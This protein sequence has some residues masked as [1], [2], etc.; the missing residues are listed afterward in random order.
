MQSWRAFTELLDPAEMA[1]ADALAIAAG[2]PGIDLM[3]AAG[4]AVAREAVR[5]ALPGSRRTPRI[6]VLC[7]PGNNGG[8][9][10]VAARL[11]AARGFAVELFLFGQAG[12]LKGDARLAADKWTGRVSPLEHF[13]PSQADL[14]VDALFGAGLARDLDGAPRAAVERVNAWRRTGGGKVLAVDVPSG[15]DGRTGKARGVAVEADATVTFFRLKPGH[16]LLPGRRLCGALRLA[17]IG[18]E[19]AVLEALESRTRLNAPGLW[20]SCFPRLAVEGHKYSRGHVLV[21]SGPAGRTGAARLSARGALRVGAGLVTLAGHP[22]AM[23]ELAAHLTAV[24]LTPCGSGSD[25][26]RILG[27]ARR[28]AVV[29]GPGLGVDHAA[30]DLLAAALGAP[31]NRGIVL[32]ADALTLF[33]SDPQGFADMV[34]RRDGPVVLTPHE[35]E[36]SRLARGLSRKNDSVSQ[37]LES[38]GQAP[39]SKLEAAR[40]MARAL[41]TILVLK[42]PDTVVASPDGRASIAADLPPDLATAGSGDVLAG[43]IGGLLAQGMPAYEAACAAVWLHGAAG[44]ALGRGLAA[45]DVPEALPGVLALPEVGGSG[46]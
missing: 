11:L 39:D 5:L 3:E 24:M 19:A 41:G 1:R 4:E 42:G 37:V 20:R 40:A 38:N 35:G 8:D 18:I 13:E 30:R 32:D 31:Q 2:A 15:L 17:Q 14:V 22:D 45:E 21:V 7:G 36:F 23:P 34:A 16:I 9:G 33:A 10:F 46:P 29:L 25:L 28:N 12:A 43:M 26:V 44:R 27:D 6:S